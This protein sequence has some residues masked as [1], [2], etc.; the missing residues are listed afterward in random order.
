MIY[1]HA[2]AA[3]NAKTAAEEVNDITPK[4]NAVLKILLI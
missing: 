4:A 3:R 2:E 1:A